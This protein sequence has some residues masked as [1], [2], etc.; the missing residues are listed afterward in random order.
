MAHC[1]RVALQTDGALAASQRTTIENLECEVDRLQRLL[2]N[3]GV[4][5]ERVGREKW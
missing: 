3:V 4:Y 5:K 1:E 2:A